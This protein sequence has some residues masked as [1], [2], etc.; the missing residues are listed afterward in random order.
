MP[1]FV[2]HPKRPAC[3]SLFRITGQNLAPFKNRQ[4]RVTL[5]TT[6]NTEF[7]EIGKISVNSVFSVVKKIMRCYQDLNG[8]QNLEELPS[9]YKL[10][11]PHAS[12]TMSGGLEWLEC[13]FTL[14]VRE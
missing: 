13:I 5:F 14:K 11:S 8:A 4:R 9:V 1:R 6:E 3:R 2:G 10:F 7:T 12:R